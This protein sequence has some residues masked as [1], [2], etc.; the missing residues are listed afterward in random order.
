MLEVDARRLQLRE[1]VTRVREWYRSNKHVSTLPTLLD[2]SPRIFRATG[3]ISALALAPG[4]CYRPSLTSPP[5]IPPA[6]SHWRS[7]PTSR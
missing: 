4:V 5:S 3:R 2:E 1:S 7:R 6:P